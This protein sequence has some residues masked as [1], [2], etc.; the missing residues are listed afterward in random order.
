[1]KKLVSG[2]EA[3]YV[4]TRSL[5]IADNFNTRLDQLNSNRTTTFQYTLMHYCT[6]IVNLASTPIFLGHTAYS[7]IDIFATNVI[8]SGLEAFTVRKLKR[9]YSHIHG[10]KPYCLS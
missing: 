1:M 8:T 5:V 6:F 2:P 4:H 3:M 7:S 9:S 10:D